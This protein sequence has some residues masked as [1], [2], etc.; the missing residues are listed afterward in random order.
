MKDFVKMTLAVICGLFIMGI[1]G[2]ILLSGFIGALASSDSA[3][4]VLPRS[5]VLKIDMSKII[6][7]EQASTINDPTSILKNNYITPIGIWN[8]VQ[9]INTAA[10]DPAV[11]LIYLKTDGAFAGMA[12]LEEF[13]KALDNFRKSG[14]AIVSYMESPTTGSYYLASVA[15]KVYMSSYSGSGPMITGVATQMFFLKDILDR[16]GVNVQLIRHGK[17]KSAGEMFIKNAPSKENLEQ[18][19]EM[20]NSIWESMAD[21]IAEKRN[22]ESTALSALIDN[23]ALESPQDMIEHKLV[24]ELVTKDELKEKLAVLEG[25]QSFKSSRLI[26]FSDYVTA[27][28][29]PDYKAKKKIAII[30]ADGEITENEDIKAIS[31]DRF[32]KI[33][34][35][36]DAD[37]SVKAVV[38]RVSSPGGS[39]LASDKIRKQLDKLGNDKLL[40]ASYGNYAASGG[41]WISNNC[42]KIFSDKTTLTGSIGV[43]SMIPDFSKTAKD[44]LKVGVANVGSNEH[45]DMYSLMKPLDEKEQAY[46]QKG[47]EKIYEEFVGNVAEGRSLRTSY[48]DS[49]AQ[50]RVWIGADALKINLVDEIGTLEDAVNYAVATIDGTTDLTKWNVTAY[51]KPMTEFESIM[52]AFGQMN[53]EEDVLAKTPFKSIVKTFK[54]WNYQTS[55]RFYARMPYEYS[56]K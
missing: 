28:T 31:G 26:R 37:S 11:K 3:K 8:A 41:Y 24:D 25:E 56:I 1:I 29:S 47:V 48:V 10:A 49:I 50:G 6:I 39:V 12:Q 42:S 5:G 22:I 45:S 30:Y 19:Q 9:A 40:V 23:L 16:F 7:K 20:I 38:L 43:F 27:K 21:E 4:P 54:D 55:E 35:D 34:A 13:R 15:D 44:I 53:Q 14:K 52:A 18:T 33:V 32:A 51:P 17:Y 2:I 46:I 36:V